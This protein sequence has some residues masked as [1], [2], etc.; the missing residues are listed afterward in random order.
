MICKYFLPFC[1]YL[2]SLSVVSFCAQKV[3]ILTKSSISIYFSCCFCFW[4]PSK[5]TSPNPRSWKF[6]P[7]FPFKSFI[8]L[9]PIFRSL[10]HFESY[11]LLNYLAFCRTLFT[12][13]P[14]N[15]HVPTSSDKC[16]LLTTVPQ[17]SI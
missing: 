1:G 14:T 11:C 16:C 7:L 8:V 9:A 3:F 6:I 10:M 17:W 15:L 12:S 2:F 13:C 5:K 4:C